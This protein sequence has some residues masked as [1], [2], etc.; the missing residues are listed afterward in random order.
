MWLQEA[1]RRGPFTPG[2]DAVIV[3]YHLSPSNSIPDASDVID[4]MFFISKW[5]LTPLW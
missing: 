4:V 5:E 2:L 3:M 1:H